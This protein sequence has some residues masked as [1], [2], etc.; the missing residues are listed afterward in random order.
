MRRTPLA[1]LFL[2]C[3]LGPLATVRASAQV[4]ADIAIRGY[5]GVGATIFTASDSFDAVLGTR[6][7]PTFGGGV[8][9]VLRDNIFIGVG[10]WRASK[11]GERVF[12]GPDDEVFPLGIPLKVTVTPIELTGGWRF[13]R[14]SQRFVPYVGG[15]FSSFKYTEDADTDSDDDDVDERFGGFHLLGGVDVRLRSWL[16]VAGEVVWTSIPDA[17]GEAG[18]SQAFDETNLGGTSVRVK[19]VIGR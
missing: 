13:T 12:V 19:V 8:D 10:A 14:L 2:F 17:L 15:G 5:G 18:V 7:L 3:L 6:S 16:G 4:P 9:V 1:L 11:D